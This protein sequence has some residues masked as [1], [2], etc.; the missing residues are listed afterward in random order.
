MTLL[1]LLARPGL[2]D[3]KTLIALRDKADIPMA[4]MLVALDVLTV[5]GM[6]DALGHRATPSTLTD[7]QVY[8]HRAIE[9]MS[10]DDAIRMMQWLERAPFLRL[11]RSEWAEGT[12]DPS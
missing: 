9:D 6:V 2:P 7:A 5:E 1:N 3:W 8:A 11:I 12:D 10:D 4:D